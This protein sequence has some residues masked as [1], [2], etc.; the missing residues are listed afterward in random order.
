MTEIAAISKL[1]DSTK[2]QYQRFREKVLGKLSSRELGLLAIGIGVLFF[3]VVSEVY[4]TIAEAFEKQAK[5]IEIAEI[6]QR[7]LATE[8]GRYV[9]NRARRDQIERKY[10]EIEMKQ[11]PRSFVEGLVSKHLNDVPQ[12]NIILKNPSDFGGAFKREGLSVKFR[13]SNYE[14]LIGLLKEMVEGKNP[15]IIS[16]LKINRSGNQLAVDMDVDCIRRKSSV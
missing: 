7:G 3:I 14:G 4:A 15:M 9:R 1:R 16:Q 5:E 8:L 12:A 13:T 6:S 2:Q 10:R 11:E